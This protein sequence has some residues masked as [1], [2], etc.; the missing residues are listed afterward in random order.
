MKLKYFLKQKINIH[1]GYLI[2]IV[3]V[4]I[5]VIGGYFSYALFTTSS[6]SKGALNI[7]T[8][9]LYALI[10]STDLDSDKEVVVAP[11]EARV[12]AMDLVN[13]NGRDAKLNLF[14]KAT[15]YWLFKKWR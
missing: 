14:Y 4:T 2:L 7:V 12:V 13:V 3:L 1:T 11:G 15:S 6:E 10:E 9:N 8:G 5:L